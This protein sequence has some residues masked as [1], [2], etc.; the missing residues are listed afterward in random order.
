M[1]YKEYYFVYIFVEKNYSMIPGKKFII[2]QT[3]LS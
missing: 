1:L 3:F 2:K